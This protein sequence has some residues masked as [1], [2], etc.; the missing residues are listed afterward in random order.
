VASE[1]QDSVG[2]TDVTPEQ[3][4]ALAALRDSV[5]FEEKAEV[6]AAEEAVAAAPV[7]NPFAPATASRQEQI[8]AGVGA[9]HLAKVAPHA[10]TTPK[11]W[12]VRTRLIS[13]QLGLTRGNKALGVDNSEANCRKLI[14]ALLPNRVWLDTFTQRVMTAIDWKSFETP[15]SKP[16]S[17]KD[18]DDIHALV[19]LQEQAGPKLRK[20]TLADAIMAYAEAHPRNCVVDWL[21]SLQW[22]GTRRLTTLMPRA[23][24]TPSTRYY[25]RVGRNLLISMV[26]RAMDPGCKVD[27][28]VVLEGPQDKLKSTA[29]EV[30]GGERHAELTANLETKDGQQQFRGVW[31]GQLPELSALRRADIERVK[32]LL[33]SR[34]DRYRPSYGRYEEEYPR[35]TVFVGTTN[36]TTW[37][38]DPT[39]N[40]RFFPVKIGKIDVSLLRQERDQLFA[41]AVALYKARRKW[42]I[43]PRLESL[44][45]QEARYIPDP[46]L[47]Q[48]HDAV[49]QLMRRSPPRPI[50]AADV[51]GAMGVP[52]AQQTQSAATRVGIALRKLGG[53]AKIGWTG[54]TN[55]TTARTWTFPG[56]VP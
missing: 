42:W 31:L 36:Q 2:P 9:Q 16:R 20:T 49:V 23:F 32:G 44:V 12:A 50:T 56:G 35:Q 27:S 29:W 48:V 25:Y 7:V 3:A 55:G 46:W 4:Q 53:V 10:V 39:G 47:D 19:F 26:A 13:E 17:W 21:N 38:Q 30:L 54:G 33:T 43:Y 18:V 1:I 8:A 45:Q 5:R 28:T 41:E 22:D 6:A 34:V 37:L 40:R 24:G 14:E 51:L 15:L 52:V 11:A